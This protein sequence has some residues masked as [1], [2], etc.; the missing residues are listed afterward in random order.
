M[1]T[2]RKPTLL[3]AT[4]FIIVSCNYITEQK[5]KKTEDPVE[6]FSWLVGKWER[7][8]EEPGKETFEN[9]GKLS[10]NEYSGIGFS[11]QGS[12]TIKQEKMRNANKT[13]NGF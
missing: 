13:E 12:G 4:I 11:V 3:T 2:L 8:H 5:T 10:Q 1:K 7:L 9:W 6:N